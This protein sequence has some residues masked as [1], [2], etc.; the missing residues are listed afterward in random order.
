[1]QD[2]KCTQVRLEAESGYSQTAISAWCSGGRAPPADKKIVKIA[3]IIGA[4]QADLEKL[5]SLARPER[6]RAKKDSAGYVR[7][8]EE[9]NHRLI[10]ALKD[11]SAELT[12]CGGEI[13]ESVQKI[14]AHFESLS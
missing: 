7:K 8:I 2:L 11:M 4:S 14:L 6:A 12:K 5:L 9:T 1:M 3:R 13:P 10:D